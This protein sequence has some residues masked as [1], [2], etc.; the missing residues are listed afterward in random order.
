MPMLQENNFVYKI[1]LIVLSVLM[2]V[3]RPEASE[4]LLNKLGLT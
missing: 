4:L 1:I 3:D 2:Q